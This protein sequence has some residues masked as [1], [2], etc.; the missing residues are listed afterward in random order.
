MNAEIYGVKL[1]SISG[2]EWTAR[3]KRLLTD[4]SHLISSLNDLSD[5]RI[6]LHSMVNPFTNSAIPV[7]KVSYYV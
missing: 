4:V 2:A 6:K 3:V 7:M 1:S 5:H